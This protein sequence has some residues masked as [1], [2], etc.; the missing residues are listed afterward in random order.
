MSFQI[1]LDV[2]RSPSEVFAFVADL[3]NMPR[4][5]DAVEQVT[6][7]TTFSG[8]EG[9]RFHMVR[10]L[11]GGRAHNDVEVTAFRPDEEVTFASVNGPTPFRYHY[12]LAPVPGG[13]RLTLDGKISAAGLTGPAALL[14]GLAER[15][16]ERG[17]RTNLGTLKRIIEAGT[18]SGR[19]SR[20]S[21]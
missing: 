2:H 6:P 21:R 19:T 20:E 4:W 15:F 17:M 18:S 5:Y 11:P 9:A 10:S 7:T 1:A 12:R 3:Q 8:G 16:F 14:G 13:T